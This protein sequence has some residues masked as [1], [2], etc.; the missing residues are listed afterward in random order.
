MKD[1]E[2]EPVPTR[3]LN[4]NASEA[5][6]KPKQRSYRKTKLIFFVGGDFYLEPIHIYRS[7]YCHI[8]TYISVATNQGHQA[9]IPGMF[10]MVMVTQ[11]GYGC[12]ARS[13]LRSP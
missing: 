1:V 9:R 8:Y 12:V 10:T 6:Y 11:P 3:V 13:W 5:S 4:P 7:I 2:R